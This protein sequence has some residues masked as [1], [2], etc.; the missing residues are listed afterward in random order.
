MKDEDRIIIYKCWQCGK[1]TKG[2][3][4]KRCEA[5]EASKCLYC[6]GDMVSLC[7]ILE[8]TDVCGDVMKVCTKKTCFKYHD[9][10]KL[11]DSWK[12]TKEAIPVETLLQ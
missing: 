2:N 6:G 9:I 1:T 12:K 8:G 10:N 5:C 11:K 7:R 4:R 3:V